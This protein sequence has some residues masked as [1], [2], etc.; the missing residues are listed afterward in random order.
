MRVDQDWDD[1]DQAEQDELLMQYEAAQEARWTGVEE[2]VESI[3][4]DLRELRGMLARVFDLMSGIVA[5][6]TGIAAIAT[7]SEALKSMQKVTADL[8]E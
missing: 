5:S 4:A 1:L 8:A 2:Q 7:N 3:F 6:T